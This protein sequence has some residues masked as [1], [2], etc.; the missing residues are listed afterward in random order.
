MNDEKSLLIVED[1]SDF[2]D[3]LMI[4][5]KNVFGKVDVA[6]NLEDALSLIQ[7]K[8]YSCIITDGVF[9][10]K[11]NYK[12]THA[13]PA[14][15]RGNAVINAAKARNILVI[16]ISSEPKYFKNADAIFKKPINISEVKNFI[17]KSLSI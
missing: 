10:E 9:P 14:D 1:D 15:F 13:S 3:S 5:F 17:K 7:K 8:N 11:G 2:R 12:I 4:I 6:S 16:G